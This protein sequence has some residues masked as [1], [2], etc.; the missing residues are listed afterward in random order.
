VNIS[1]QKGGSLS[2]RVFKTVWRRDI[3]QY[4]IRDICEVFSFWDIGESFSFLDIGGEGRLA[5]CFLCL[6]ELADFHPSIWL[7]SLH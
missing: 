1:E 7:L 6:S 3:H 5:G 4:P 2:W